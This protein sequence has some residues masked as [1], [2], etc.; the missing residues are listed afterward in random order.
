MNGRAVAG[1]TSAEYC[2]IAGGKQNSL[3]PSGPV[4]KC[5]LLTVFRCRARIFIDYGDETNV[6]YDIPLG[7]SDTQ[8]KEQQDQYIF[9]GSEKITQNKDLLHLLETSH[10][11][12]IYERRNTHAI[13]KDSLSRMCLQPDVMI[14]ERTCIQLQHLPS[15]AD[16]REYDKLRDTVLSLSLKC[17]KCCIIMHSSKQP[18]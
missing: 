7:I 1:K 13:P 17:H 12:L 10:N 14:D 15:L 11:V 6:I 5:L 8:L 3:F 16:E 9:I 18:E 2:Y 4:I